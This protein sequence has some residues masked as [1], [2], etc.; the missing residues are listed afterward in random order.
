MTHDQSFNYDLTPPIPSINERLQ[1]KKLSVS[2]YSFAMRHSILHTSTQSFAYVPY[3]VPVYPL[4]PIL[5]SK[6]D[7]KSAY[8]R[9]HFSAKS[10]LHSVV[11]TSGL[12]EKKTLL[13]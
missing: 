9:I 4:Q 1:R 8:R 12:G 10:A 3:Q 2:V 5:I 7:F 6:F 11:S 13:L